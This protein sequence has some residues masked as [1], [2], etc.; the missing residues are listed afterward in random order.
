MRSPTVALSHK[1]HLENVLRI[2]TIFKY[3]GIK[4]Y[5]DTFLFWRAKRDAI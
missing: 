2:M 4:Y 5:V 3:I 1:L